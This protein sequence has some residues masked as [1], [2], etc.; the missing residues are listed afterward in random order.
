MAVLWSSGH[1][2]SSLQLVLTLINL[3]VILCSVIRDWKVNG[4]VGNDRLMV[5][6]VRG[7]LVRRN[8]VCQLV[9]KI[10]ETSID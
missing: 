10:L 6:T 4:G 5:A 3:F 7:K 9:D 1:L 8:S 2:L